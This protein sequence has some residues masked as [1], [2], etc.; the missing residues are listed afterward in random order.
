MEPLQDEDSIK[1][2]RFEM[3]DYTENTKLAIIGVI[4]IAFLSIWRLDPAIAKDVVQV[5]VAGLIGY[6]A[7][8]KEV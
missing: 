2:W 8:G 7:R 3:I 6:I 4:L 1:E 5:S